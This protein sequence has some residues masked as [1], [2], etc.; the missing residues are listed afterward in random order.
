MGK[1]NFIALD[2]HP[3][4]VNAVSETCQLITKD[5]I[6]HTFNPMEWHVIHMTL[7]YLGGALGTDRKQKIAVVQRNIDHFSNQFQGVVLEF[8]GYCLFPETKRNLIVAKFK[9]VDREFTNR[10]IEFKKLFTAI[11]AQE[12]DFFVAHITLGKLGMAHVNTEALE[13]FIK[14]LPP[15]N[16]RIHI[17]SCHLCG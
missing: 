1:T 12:E 4:F 13:V 3:D 7:C 6:T 11:G 5:L 17:S 14:A 8:D 9:C 16:T 15:I 2:L 10:M